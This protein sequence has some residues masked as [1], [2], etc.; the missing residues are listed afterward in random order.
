MESTGKHSA[1]YVHGAADRHAGVV[2]RI[3]AVAPL[4]FQHTV[5]LL[6]HRDALAATDIEPGLH[7]VMNTTVTSRLFIALD[8]GVGADHHSLFTHTEVIC[9]SRGRMPTHL[10]SLREELC[11]FLSDK[12]PDLAEYLSDEKRLAQLSCLA[13][14]FTETNKLNKTLQDGNKNIIS[15]HVFQRKTKTMENSC[16]IR[17][18]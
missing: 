8:E 1:E 18:H 5:F 14:I 16:L 9:L 4:P 2:Q 13:D 10:F 15:Q 11:I 3:K 6:L 12:T 7:D 17:N